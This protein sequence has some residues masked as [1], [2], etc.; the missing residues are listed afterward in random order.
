MKVRLWVISRVIKNCSASLVPGSSQKFDE[1]FVNHF[2]ACFGGDVAAEIDSQF[3]GDFEVI[4][5]PGVA[6]L[7]PGK[8]TWRQ[9][10]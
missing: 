9:R 1:A 10:T 6:G 3:T 4:R 8:Q 5:C 2:G 7:E